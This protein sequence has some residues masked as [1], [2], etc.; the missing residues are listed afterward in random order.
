M[1]E[2]TIIRIRPDGRMATQMGQL[3]F[4]LDVQHDC[5]QPIVVK[6]YDISGWSLSSTLSSMGPN[7]HW[8]R[9]A[10]R[11]ELLQKR[12]HSLDALRTHCVCL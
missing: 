9:I 12:S 1:P 11:G 4:A 8:H 10:T 3:M 7:Q 5:R 6:G 2:K